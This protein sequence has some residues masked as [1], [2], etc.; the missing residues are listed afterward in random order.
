MKINRDK[1]QY[2]Y[3]KRQIEGNVE[4]FLT[5]PEILVLRGPRQ[6]GKTTLIKNISLQLPQENVF[7]FTFEDELIKNKFET[8]PQEFINFY[9][10]DSTQKYFFL[11]DEVQYLS[12]AGKQLK[13]IFDLF[14][15]V[16]LIVTGSSTLD[17]NQLGQYLVGRAIYFEIMPFSFDEF[18]ETKDQKL[19][20]EYKKKKF[21]LDHPQVTNS[22]FIDE[23]NKNL[24]EYITYG[25]YP[26]VVLETDLQ[27]KQVLL[28][29]I[30]STYVEKDIIQLFGPK[31]R[32]HL[33]SVLKYLGINLGQLLQYESLGN[34]VNL[35][36]PQVKEVLDILAQT[37]IIQ[38]LHP[39]HKNQTTELKKNPKLYFIDLGMR[40]VLLD[41]FEFDDKE[42][43]YLLENFILNQFKDQKVKFWRTTAK[44]EV[45]FV[46]TQEIIPLEVKTKA[47]VTRSFRSFVDT[48]QPRI[49][50]ITDL[51][52]SK[53]EL[54]GKSKIFI[55]PVAL[56]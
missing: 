42:Y 47:K 34:A 10:T 6:A 15:H 14:P 22:I 9:A 29:N 56:I 12:Q 43:G 38:S 11:L 28:R 39:F 46:L 31:H 4:K 50:L 33:L 18:L 44:A 45:D 27:K 7:Y 54:I 40:N 49:G 37:Y 53:E 21:N 51:T 1:R 17:L 48:Y 26:R 55:T 2:T 36:Y 30:F 35:N 24:R 3:I 52:N 32:H 41:K 13:L 23:L 19:L 25:G 16:K 20:I 8:N 5:D